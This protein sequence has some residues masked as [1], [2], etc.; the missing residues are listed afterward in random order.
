[1]IT[2][3]VLRV[4]LVLFF[5]CVGGCSVDVDYGGTG[6]AC[7]QGECP[8]GYFCDG[9]RCLE[10]GTAVCGNGV[11][12][13]GEDCEDSSEPCCQDCQF[14]APAVVCR[15]ARGACDSA[16]S[17]SGTASSCPTDTLVSLGTVCRSKNSECDVADECSGQADACPT[18]VVARDGIACVAGVCT[19]GLCDSA[20]LLAHWPLEGTGPLA[21]DVSGNGHDAQIV[22]GER[23]EGRLGR[24][25]RFAGSGDHI[26]E[27]QAADYLNGLLGFTLTIWVRADATASDRGFINTVIPAAQGP[28]G[29][30][31]SLRY[32]AEGGM[33]D[34]LNVLKVGAGTTIDVVQLESSAGSQSTEWQ[35]VAFSW[36]E[37]TGPQLFL[38]GALDSPSSVDGLPVGAID[39]VTTLLIGRGAKDIDTSW[40]GLIDDV[41]IYNRVLTPEEIQQLFEI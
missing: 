25:I 8:T 4:A 7:I 13:S 32:D 34:A 19:S 23:T 12:E 35:F 30:G 26:V 28:D 22:D 33:G 5:A 20:D 11:L 21:I 15:E 40:A 27:S 1:M 17:C 10:E 18:D 9:S 37:L 24:G 36:S 3:S 14:A 41:R 29:Q 16:E 2:L 38:N 6:F 31:I 39:R